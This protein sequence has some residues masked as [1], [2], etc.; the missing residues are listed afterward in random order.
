MPEIV[1][2][3]ETGIKLV[4]ISPNTTPKVIIS[5]NPKIEPMATLYGFSCSRD[6]FW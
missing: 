5:P 3:S 2:I 4:I 1:V 6:K